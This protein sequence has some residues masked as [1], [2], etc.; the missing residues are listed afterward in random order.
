VSLSTHRCYLPSLNYSQLLVHLQNKDQTITT[1]TEENANIS[2]AL[3][4]AEA[5]LYDFFTEQARM[6]EEMSA[7]I[8]V[9]EKLRTQSREL[10]KEKRDLHRR[11]NE[12]VSS[13][14]RH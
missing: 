1:L 8:E 9:A 7:R 13:H 12:Q 14:T 2:T 3:N 11:Y 4:T 5:Q 10:E 6:E